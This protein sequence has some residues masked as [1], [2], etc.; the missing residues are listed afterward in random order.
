MENR[1]KAAAIVQI[2]AG[3]LDLLL[4]SW[5]AAFVWL[6]F[7]GTISMFVMAICTLGLCPLPIGGACAAVGIPIALVGLL[8]I[9]SGIAGVLQPKTARPFALVVAGFGV[10]SIFLANPVSVVAGVVT[11]ALLATPASA[12][13]EPAA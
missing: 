5:V 10:L 6:T 8:E 13:A 2:I 9:I 1:V 11:F 4:V 3:V 7:G 12:E